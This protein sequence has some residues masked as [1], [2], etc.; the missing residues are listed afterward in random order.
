ML[1]ATTVNDRLKRMVDGVCIHDIKIALPKESKTK[2]FYNDMLAQGIDSASIKDL[3]QLLKQTAAS[4]S[5]DTRFINM[6]QVLDVLEAIDGD[7][8]RVE[9]CVSLSGHVIDRENARDARDA[10]Y[11]NLSQQ[12]ALDALA[13]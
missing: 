12:E 10:I 1:S 9:A 4:A 8:Y 11:S 7:F 2:I 3:P 13:K 5:R 6:N